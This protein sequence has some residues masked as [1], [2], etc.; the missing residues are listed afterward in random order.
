L[1]AKEDGSTLI[2]G[3]LIKYIVENMIKDPKDVEVFL[4]NGTV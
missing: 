3:D 1:P 4:E 2:L